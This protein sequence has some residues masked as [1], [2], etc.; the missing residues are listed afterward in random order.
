MHALHRTVSLVLLLAPMACIVEVPEGGSS[1]SSSSS[2][3]GSTGEPAT[4]SEAATD[5]TGIVTTTMPPTTGTTEAAT[6]PDPTSS[7]TGDGTTGPVEPD[8][9]GD[10]PHVLLATSM[11]DMIVK[12]DR[13]KAPN[14]V[15]NFM[16]YVDAGFYDGTI[17]HRV[18]IDFVIQGGGY[19]PDL[20]EKPTNPPIDLEISDLLHVD[21]A[22]SMART[23]EPNSATSQF[24]ICD[25]PQP[26]LDGNYAVFGV[27]VSGFEVRDAIADVA[28]GEESG[29]MDVPVEDVILE[30]AYCVDAP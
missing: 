10:T 27:L 5:S 1:G 19:T 3:S 16:S 8:C 25:G 14:T 28:V 4:D 17:F 20:T 22:I 13:V 7:S 12:L 23:M 9:S 18:I 11:G 2:S 29:F 15:A 26:G 6:E 30:M 24:Y 21:G